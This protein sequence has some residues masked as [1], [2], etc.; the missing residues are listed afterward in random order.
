MSAFEAAKKSCKTIHIPKKGEGGD[1]RRYYTRWF[2]LS[3]DKILKSFL[4]KF[5]KNISKVL[6]PYAFRLNKHTYICSL[7]I[8][9]QYYK[10]EF[11]FLIDGLYLYICVSGQCVVS[12]FSH[13]LNPQEPHLLI[14]SNHL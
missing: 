7:L 5:E 14:N 8:L 12:Q 9:A 2:T 11:M 3:D 6:C 1:N 13:V 10:I 4:V